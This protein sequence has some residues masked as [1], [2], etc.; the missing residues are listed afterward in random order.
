MSIVLTVNKLIRY[1]D[2]SDNPEILRILYLDNIEDIAYVIN[3]YGD[4]GLPT[5]CRPSSLIEDLEIGKASIVAKDPWATA[6]KDDELSDSEKHLRNEA[7][8]VISDLVVPSNEPAIFDRNKRGEL[9]EEAG[10]NHG[11]I[12]LTVYKYMRR[13]WQRGKTKNAL[14][15]DFQNSGGKGKERKAG[16]VKR[17][18]KRKFHDVEDIGEGVNVDESMKKIFRTAVSKFYRNPKE[19]SLKDA[20]SLMIAEY[21]TEETVFDEDGVKRNILIPPEKRP[22]LAQ[23]Q[24]WFNK[25]RN[26]EKDITARRGKTLMR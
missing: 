23:F 22:T 20:F 16:E 3:I 19:M 14:I 26:V 9:F 17:G 13:Y 24:Y 2:S 6:V 5:F 25:E 18:R 1:G 12:P 11:A 15:P 4:K 10:K 8:K 21:F 7:W